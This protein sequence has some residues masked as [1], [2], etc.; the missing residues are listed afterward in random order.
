MEM[1]QLMGSGLRVP[2][3]SFGTATFGGSN[4][5]FKAWGNTDAGGAKKLIDVCLEAGLNFFDTANSYSDGMAEE[6]LGHAIHGKRN[7]LLIST[8]ASIALGEGA[9]DYG[10]SRYN[11]IRQ[12]EGSLRRLKTDHIDMYYIHVF[13]A[14]TP[15]EETMRALDD[16]VSQG[17]VRYVGCSNYSGWQLMKSQLKAEQNAWSKFSMHQVYY[18]LAGREYEWELMQAGLDQKVSAQI[19]SPL[20]AGA[21]TGKFRRGKEAPKSTR[22]MQTSFPVAQIAEPL[23]KIIDALDMVSKETGKTLSQVA[24]NWL[25]QRPTVANIIVGARNEEQLRENLGAVGWSLSKE[26]VAV[27]DQASAVTP[28]Y[29][30]WHQRDF[31]QHNPGRLI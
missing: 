7:D 20:A 17:K 21:L 13:D 10:S 22:L 25:L 29:P 9:N 5:F 15:V 24:L 2:A 6:I 4:D 23:Y 8:K 14:T 16:L 26:L 18:S 3:L 12:C 27:L 1:R 30:Y 28:I 11:L 19:W 31:A